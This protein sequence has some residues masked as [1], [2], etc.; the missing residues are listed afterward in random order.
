[1]ARSN[2]EG[3]IFSYKLGSRE[4]NLALDGNPRYD[5]TRFS[6]QVDH[7][8]QFSFY[9]NL[10][11]FFYKD[12]YS[13]PPGVIGHYGSVRIY[14]LTNSQWKPVA[15]G[16]ELTHPRKELA[17]R[18]ACKHLVDTTALPFVISNFS[19]VTLA[20]F[21]K[22]FEMV[23]GLRISYEFK[24]SDPPNLRVTIDF[25]DEGCS[26]V[27]EAE[28][29]N[30]RFAWASVLRQIADLGIMKGF[31]DYFPSLALREMRRALR[32]SVI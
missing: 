19:E 4:H 7:W 12:F 11:F 31:H 22:A 20:A 23:A 29:F 28:E 15:P 26:E 27:F 24:E 2:K 1:M 30:L 16:V 9:P 18:A 10:K 8:F 5:E 25:L 3:T 21:I 14:K 17:H 13:I 6:H 32:R